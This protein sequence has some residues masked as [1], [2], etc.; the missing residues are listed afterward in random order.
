[1]CS[2]IKYPINLDP[3]Q[4][5][6]L[7]FLLKQI[8]KNDSTLSGA[9]FSGILTI[10]GKEIELPEELIKPEIGTFL[11]VTINPNKITAL[12]EML[13]QTEKSKKRFGLLRNKYITK[14]ES[15]T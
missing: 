15:A 13:S 2:A 5:I 1:M 10:F 12:V 4:Q 6:L 9:T 3:N 8:N 11:H 14:K 7:S